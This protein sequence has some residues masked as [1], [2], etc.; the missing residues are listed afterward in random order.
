MKTLIICASKYGSTLEI[1]RWL[2]ER[3]GGCCLVDKAESMSDPA[4]ADLVILG[5]GIYNYHVLPSAQEYVNHFK[6]ALKGKKTVV[7]GVALDTTGV[8]VQGKVHGGW[9]YI[10]PLIKNL[11]EPPIHAG[12][13]GGEIN[14]DKLDARDT[15]GLKR[16]YKML[17]GRETPIPYKTRM[18]KNEVWAFAEKILE[19]LERPF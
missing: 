18:D 3:L 19:R 1:G 11:P 9:N 12:L 16:F 10:L 15:E 14:P 5:S 7:F 13:L 4:D 2:A 8:F 6:D 17:Y